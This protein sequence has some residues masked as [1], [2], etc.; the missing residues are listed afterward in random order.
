M[1]LLADLETLCGDCTVASFISSNIEGS[2]SHLITNI[3]RN[4]LCTSETP[5][6]GPLLDEITQIGLTVIVFLSQDCNRSLPCLQ[7]HF[8]L[9]NEEYIFVIQHTDQMKGAK[10]C[11]SS[12]G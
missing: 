6:T 9:N 4:F 5:I 2:G 10:A 12:E 3:D 8:K 1:Q 7:S 11:C